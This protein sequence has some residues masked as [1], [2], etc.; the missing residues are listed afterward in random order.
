[1]DLAELH[2]MTLNVLR[3]RYRAYKE[4]RTNDGQFRQDL[5][6]GHISDEVAHRTLGLGLW[7]PDQPI[8]A[9]DPQHAG[10]E[11]PEEDRAT[12]RSILWQLVGLGILIP[13]TMHDE[14]NQF[15]DL[16]GYGK[17][18][19]E[20]GTETPYDPL[21]FMRR[22]QQEA[23]LLEGETI[24]F[25]QEALDCYLSRHFRASA[26]M[27]GLASEN[28]LL[29]LIHLYSR[30][31]DPSEGSAFTQQMAKR[32]QVKEKFDY[33]Y[34]RLQAERGTLPPS[35]RELDTWLQGMF[36]VIRLYRNDGG[37]PTSNAPTR[38]AVYANLNLFMTYARE[39][40][41]LKAHLATG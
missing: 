23:P 5:S 24:A 9:D 41:Q 12:V 34:Q 37:H 38:E 25:V 10:H 13:R 27:L 30:T 39:L 36:H 40:S 33:L 18:V 21:G 31:K 6:S 20:E 16:A 2:E 1:M 7:K 11:F 3:D 26:V 19:L 22:L 8:R 15:F 14:R 35:I 32:R 17:I 29:K 4:G 28:E